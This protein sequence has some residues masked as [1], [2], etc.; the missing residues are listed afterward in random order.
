VDSSSL[1]IWRP[2]QKSSRYNAT[3]FHVVK[4]EVAGAGVFRSRKRRE[5]R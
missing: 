5:P 3:F 4:K 1:T 2:Q